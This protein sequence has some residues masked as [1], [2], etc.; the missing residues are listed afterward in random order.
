MEFFGPSHPKALS[1]VDAAF[2][3][4]KLT[5]EEALEHL[6]ARCVDWDVFPCEGMDL[7]L[8]TGA[9]IVEWATLGYWR[10]RQFGLLLALSARLLDFSI[11]ILHTSS[12]GPKYEFAIVANRGSTIFSTISCG[13]SKS[14]AKESVAEA[15]IAEMGLLGWLLET[16]SETM[17]D[18]NLIEMP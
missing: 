14:K 18:E 17:C 7:R 1:P 11:F 5:V 3:T 16:H 10:K 13:S 8:N 12:A 2:S 9:T 4:R 15:I 6:P